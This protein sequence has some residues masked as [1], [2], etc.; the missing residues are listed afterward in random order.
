MLLAA[1]RESA[2]KCHPV[3]AHLGRRHPN[4]WEQSAWVALFPLFVLAFPL[5]IFI[6]PN[7]NSCCYREIIPIGVSVNT[8]WKVFPNHFPSRSKD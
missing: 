1:P 3:N 4:V 6:L 7:R 5:H 8:K 2:V